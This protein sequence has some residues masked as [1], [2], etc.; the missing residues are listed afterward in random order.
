MP[1]CTRQL[2]LHDDRVQG[3]KTGML[4]LEA[5]VGGAPL[6]HANDLALG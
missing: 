4:M 1:E 2:S 6:Q 3:Y 5:A